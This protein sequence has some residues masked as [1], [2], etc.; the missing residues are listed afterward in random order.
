M[1][2]KKVFLNCWKSLF[3]SNASLSID[4]E[5]NLLKYLSIYFPIL[6]FYFLQPTQPNKPIS[7]NSYVIEMVVLGYQFSEKLF[8][9]V[10]RNSRKEELNRWMPKIWDSNKNF[11][12][13]VIVICKENKWVRLRYLLL[14][15]G[16][17]DQEEMESEK[18]SPK[19]L[20]QAQLFLWHLNQGA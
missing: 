17:N 19:I 5:T 8:R 6:L 18:N 20:F 7:F 1:A 10:R 3:T 16:S 15:E 9:V 11:E 13:W 14:E 4:I 2:W 12:L